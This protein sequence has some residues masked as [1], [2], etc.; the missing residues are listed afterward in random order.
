MLNFKSVK[1]QLI[2]YLVCFGVFLKFRGEHYSFLFSVLT[3]VTAAVV[4]ESFILYLK[5]RKFQIT[6]SSVI[7]GLIIGFVLSSYEPWWKLALAAVLAI[8]SK[9]LLRFRQK[10]IFNPAALGIFLIT[11]IFDA[12]TQW[13][14]TYLWYILVPF[15]LYFTNKIRKIEVIAGYLLVSL[16]LFGTQA[17]LLNV[18]LGNIFGYLSYFYI[19]VMVIEP[20]TT[21]IKT[22]GKYLFGAATAGL[23]FVLTEAGIGF[24]AELF[25]LLAMNAVF[26]LI[27]GFQLKRRVA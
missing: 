23:V 22:M 13:K 19:F 27:N 9:H 20:K 21:P 24:D 1:T 26:R 16:G 18:P 25:S 14:G 15:G 7:T 5:T 17:L 6:E 8:S 12:S 3:A 10:H 2:I 11:V 4:I